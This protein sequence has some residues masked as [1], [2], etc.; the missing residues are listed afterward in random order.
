MRV[1]VITPYLARPGADGGGTVMF[2]FIRHLS[3]RHEIFYLTFARRQDLVHLSEIEPFCRETVTVALPGGTAGSMLQKG[4]H[5]AR[6][7][8]QNM[9]SLA[10]FTPVVVQKC[11]SR[12]MDHEIRRSIERCRPDVVHF[13]FP[14]MA[15]YVEACAGVP[16]VMDTLDVALVGVLRRAL[17]AGSLWSK[18]YYLLQW[19]FWVRYERRFFPRFGKVLT[20]THQDEAALKMILPDLDV[21]SDSV[22]VDLEGQPELK[23]RPTCRIGFL[24][25][26]GHQPNVDAALYFSQEIFPRVRERLADAEF[27]VAGKNPPGFLLEGEEGGIRCLGF[28]PDVAA[29]YGSVD[30]VVAPIRFGGGIKLKVLEAMACGKPVVTTSVGAEGILLAGDDALLVADDPDRF[31]GEVVALLSDGALRD[32]L[33]KRARRLVER[34]FSWDRVVSDL[35]KI[36]HG[37]GA[38]LKDRDEVAAS[39]AIGDGL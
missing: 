21:Y 28:V 2:N 16:A 10:T 29:F 26:F 23:D 11:R 5:L 1:L 34:R 27:V 37:L 33:G 31:A 38:P 14:Q 20:V 32:A 8:V 3:A 15:H 12:A 13:C 19:F 36:Y 39:D 4:V 30:V 25:S 18:A 9:L 24:A 6:R 17:N 7:V 22:A 35:E